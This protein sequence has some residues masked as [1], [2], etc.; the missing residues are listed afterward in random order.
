MSAKKNRDFRWDERT[1]KAAR[2]IAEGEL[3]D[4]EVAATVGVHPSTIWRWK[5]I[6]QFARR[7]AK[8]SE[9]IEAAIQGL[10]ISVRVRRVKRLND[11]MLKI[12][13][14]FAE[15]ANDKRLEHVP[16]GSTGL[17]VHNVKGVG[18]GEDFQLI[19]L[20]E[21]D[22]GSLRE[23]REVMKQAAIETGQWAEKQDPG[24]AMTA[25]QAIEAAFA[26]KAALDQQRKDD[27][28]S[29]SSV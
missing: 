1:K 4:H 9:R 27:Q 11:V 24:G 10:P 22:V 6:P 21:V 25:A 14:V 26:A 15:R 2:L 29:G 19:D 7:V 23:L 16:G 3:L 8:L 28:S 20:Y 13:K 18:K 17:I 5:A 12:E